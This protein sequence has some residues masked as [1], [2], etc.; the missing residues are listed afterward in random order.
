M[1]STV[2]VIIPV[3]NVAKYLSRCVE[4]IISQDYGDLQ[5]ILI[6]DG[7]TDGSAELCD[8]FA[9]KDRRVLTVHQS[10]HGVA[11]ARNAGLAHVAGGYIFFLDSDDFIEKETLSRLMAHRTG[12]S[13]ICCGSDRYSDNDGNGTYYKFTEAGDESYTSRQAVDSMLFGHKVLSVLWG[14]LYEAELF[15]GI[16]FPE[17]EIHE[18]ESIIYIVLDRAEKIFYLG[19]VL[20]HYAIREGSITER[21]YSEANLAKFEAYASRADYFSQKK[22][23]KEYEYTIVRIIDEAYWAVKKDRKYRKL[24]REKVSR[25]DL[26]M[27]KFGFYTAAEK[28]K[29]MIKRVAA[30]HIL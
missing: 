13:I 20:Y 26:H 30:L 27:K 18:D 23:E 25:T 4:S 7:S 19:D 6:D 15:S 3:Y 22:Y 21:E 16:R 10:N 2:S 28:F 11:A 17:G 1:N 14:K 12:Y 8:S 29:F 9:E 5:I 24:I